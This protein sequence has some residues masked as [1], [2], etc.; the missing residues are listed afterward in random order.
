M[1]ECFSCGVSAMEVRLFDGL[2]D[3]GL[4]R[5]CSQCALD[6]GIMLVKKPTS[7]ELKDSEKKKDN[8]FKVKYS[9]KAEREKSEDVSLK[10]IVDETYREKYKHLEKGPRPDLVDNFHWIVMR[11]RRKRHITRKQLAEE[12]AESESAIEMV[13]KG[14]LPEDDNHLISK[15]QSFLGVRL[16]KPGQDMEYKERV[17]KK[18]LD[19]DPVSL[20]SITIADLREMQKTPEKEKVNEEKCLL[21]H[22]DEES[23]LVLDKKDLEKTNI[24]KK[25]IV[26]EEDLSFEDMDD[27]IF[28]KRE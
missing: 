23:C 26:S 25:E 12:I 19:F 8:S 2:A 10:K 21:E 16:I 18:G 15:L 13:E 6:E 24:L 9:L 3:E 17:A 5:V 22:E 27:L 1:E 28:R 14:V 4:V 7:V 20:K 11:V